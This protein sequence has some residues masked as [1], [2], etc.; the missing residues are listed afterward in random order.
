M[1]D[2]TGPLVMRT[3]VVGDPGAPAPPPGAPDLMHPS[4]KLFGTDTPGGEL[5]E[6]G[7]EGALLRAK[8]GSAAV[9]HGS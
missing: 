2:L 8:G 9:G 4:A 6:H 7:I 1:V 5:V 3:G